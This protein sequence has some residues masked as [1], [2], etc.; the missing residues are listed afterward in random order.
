MKKVK[1]ILEALKKTEQATGKTIL[2]IV[3]INDLRDK[4]DDGTIQPEEKRA[5]RNYEVYRINKLNKLKDEDEFH[6]EYKFLQALANLSPF[7]EFL[8]EKYAIQ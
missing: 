7:E 6:D 3:T 8:T 4:E 1:S 5:L 2:D